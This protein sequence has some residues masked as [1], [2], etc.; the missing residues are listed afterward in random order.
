MSVAELQVRGAGEAEHWSL[1]VTA[2][3]D[4][5]VF[6]ECPSCLHMPPLSAAWPFLADKRWDRAQMARS[7]GTGSPQVQPWKVR[8]SAL[9]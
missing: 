8:C 9:L 5:G 1:D 6:G 2:Q 4:G 7:A 3:V